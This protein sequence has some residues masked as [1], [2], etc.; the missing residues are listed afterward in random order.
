[1]DFY[2]ALKYTQK[3]TDISGGM[4]GTE[5][6]LD[7]AAEDLLVDIFGYETRALDLDNKGQR[8]YSK[9]NY[10]QAKQFFECSL[11]IRERALGPD[12]P[13]VARSLYHLGLLYKT[14]RDYSQA[15][16]FYKRS[17]AIREKALGPDHPDVVTSL[18]SLAVLY[19]NQGDYAQAEPL[20]KRS[21][22]IR[23]KALGPDHPDVATSLHN[24]AGL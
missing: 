23:E 24:L 2:T 9:R 13:D 17:L 8:Y 7:K 3:E 19:D 15:E 4:M 6:E 12:H 14:Q 5:P 22:A 20:Y 11:E 16:P 18:N 1:M 21:L 10:A